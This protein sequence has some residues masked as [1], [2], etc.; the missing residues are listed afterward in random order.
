MSGDS[1]L[2]RPIS[3]PIEGRRITSLDTLVG[4]DKL[5][6]AFTR[7]IEASVKNG[8]ATSDSGSFEITTG[9]AHRDP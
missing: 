8:Q 9:E 7:T 2:I 3:A 1:P 4:L 5:L 6:G